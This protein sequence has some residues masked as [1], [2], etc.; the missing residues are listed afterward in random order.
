[1]TRI[2]LLVPDEDLALIDS[3][4]SPNRTAFMI[5]AA[6]REA[7]RIR[8]MREDDE[9][10]RICAETAHRDEELAADFAATIGDGL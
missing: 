6:K 9:I 5:E 3:A 1:M 10:A 8:R 2:S 7:V 4:A